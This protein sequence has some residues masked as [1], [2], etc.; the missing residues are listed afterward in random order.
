MLCSNDIVSTYNERLFRV[1]L[2]AA[3]TNGGDEDFS[4]HILNKLCLALSQAME[5][6]VPLKNF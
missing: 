3:D 6:E 2:L 4:H 5:R 1:G